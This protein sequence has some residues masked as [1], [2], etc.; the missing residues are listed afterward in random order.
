MCVSPVQ[1]VRD[2]SGGAEEER[3]YSFIGLSPNSAPDVLSNSILC[4][5]YCK[6]GGFRPWRMSV[7]IPVDLCVRRAQFMAVLWVCAREHPGTRRTPLSG[8]VRYHPPLC[9]YTCREKGSGT[10]R[11]PFPPLLGPGR[12]GFSLPRVE[13]KAVRQVLSTLLLLFVLWHRV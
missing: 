4:V 13:E 8:V 9:S 6:T 10:S 5:S 11:T 3:T 2:H 12:L 1:S 7:C